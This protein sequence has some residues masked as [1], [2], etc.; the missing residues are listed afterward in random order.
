MDLDLS[1]KGAIESSEEDYKD[2]KPEPTW[3]RRITDEPT[4]AGEPD[5]FSGKGED[6]MRWLMAMKA[7]FE[8]H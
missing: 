5:S 4:L 2:P 7:Y 1:D 6:T 8:L 3:I